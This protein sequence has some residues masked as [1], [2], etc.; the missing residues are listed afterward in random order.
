MREIG[1]WIDEVHQEADNRMLIHARDMLDAGINT[2]VIRTG[3][4]DVIVIFLA[5][6]MQF[7][8]Y[9]NSNLWIEMG[10]LGTTCLI[11]VVFFKFVK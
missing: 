5:F 2:I 8:Q 4:T 11:I 3:V 7:R 6:P 9:F 10:N 1:K